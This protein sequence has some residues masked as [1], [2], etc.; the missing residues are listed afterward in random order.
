LTLDATRSS[1]GP[2]ARPRDT[3]SRLADNKS[4][5]AATTSLWAW[6]ASHTVLSEAFHIAAAKQPK[7]PGKQGFIRSSPVGEM[8][9][10]LLYRLA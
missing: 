7:T 5:P 3:F 2:E 1:P 8:V 9:R 6:L 4:R 10:R